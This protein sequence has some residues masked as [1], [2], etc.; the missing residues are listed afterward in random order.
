MTKTKITPLYE[1]LSRHEGII[2]KRHHAGLTD[3]CGES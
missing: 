3:Q 2:G 1:R